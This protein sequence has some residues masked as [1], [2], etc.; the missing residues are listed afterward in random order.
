MQEKITYGAGDVSTYTLLRDGIVFLMDG[1]EIT[2]RLAGLFNLYNALAAI[3]VAR[4][5]GVS[6]GA[7]ASALDGFVG[8]PGRME[9]IDEGQAFMVVVDYAHTPDSLEKVYE[10]FALHRKICVLGSCGGGRDVWKRPKLGEI[11]ARHCD[12][13]IVTD[14]D[15]Y[16]EDPRAIIDAVAEAIPETKR[17]VIPDRKDAIREAVRRARTGDAVIIT[18]KGAE[19]WMMGPNETKTPWDDRAVAR[20]ALRE[21]V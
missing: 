15:P 20:D 18:G 2:T 13:V 21:V 12:E 8:I 14:E 16:D 11:A 9:Y 10:F 17:T 1:V 5:E 7:I 4:R 6:L 3:A 19:P